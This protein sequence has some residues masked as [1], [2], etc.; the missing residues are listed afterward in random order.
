MPEIRSVVNTHTLKIFPV[1]VLRNK[2]K[3]SKKW[4]SSVKLTL[5]IKRVRSINSCLPQSL[6]STGFLSRE[7]FYFYLKL[8]LMELDVILAAFVEWC[9]QLDDIINNVTWV[10]DSSVADEELVPN[11]I[12][13]FNGL[14][15][16]SDCGKIDCDMKKMSR[17]PTTTVDFCKCLLNP[18]W[19]WIVFSH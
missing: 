16:N 19:H 1:F 18:L 9:S 7:L 12:L 3:Q 17:S 2:K 10:T 6:F 13:C 14:M 8:N 15:S 5:I 11:A 4:S